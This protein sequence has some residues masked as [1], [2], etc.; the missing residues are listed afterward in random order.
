MCQSYQKVEKKNTWL[1]R[2]T[3]CCETILIH[4]TKMTK[5]FKKKYRS[6][7]GKET[8]AVL[9]ETMFL[10]RE[11]KQ[12]QSCT[13]LLLTTKFVYLIKFNL[14]SAW[15]CTKLLFQSSLFT[16][17]PQLFICILICLIFH[18]KITSS[19]TKLYFPF[20]KMYFNSSYLPLL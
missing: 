8:Q 13:S 3:G 1:N 6:I 15:Q 5:D 14:I 12:I 10:N 20:N 4:L 16:N 18:P 9:Q 11:R 7:K 17:L 2:I 19:R